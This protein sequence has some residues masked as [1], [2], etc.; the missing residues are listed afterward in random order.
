MLISELIKT[1][2]D[3]QAQHGDL[4]IYIFDHEMGNNNE[5][6]DIEIKPEDIRIDVY[7]AGGKGGDDINM[8]LQYIKLITGQAG[9]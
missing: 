2:Q 8:I 4:P 6:L 7:R 1:L 9:L 3:Y 5:I